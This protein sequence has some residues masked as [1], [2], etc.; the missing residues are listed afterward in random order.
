MEDEEYLCTF[1]EDEDS[2]NYE[3]YK[4]VRSSRNNI[5]KKAYFVVHLKTTDDEPNDVEIVSE[6]FCL[7]KKDI[8]SFKRSGECYMRYDAYQSL[9]GQDIEDIHQI[10]L[11]DYN[12]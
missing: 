4:V 12:F 1:W 11:K 6:R 9:L 2:F 10:I 5:W 3:Y 8:V 7:L